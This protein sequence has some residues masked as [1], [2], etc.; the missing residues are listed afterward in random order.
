MSEIAA[1]R[2]SEL[3]SGDK[4]TDNQAWMDEVIK[5][6]RESVA[7]RAAAPKLSADEFSAASK[8]IF[9]DVD[10]DRDGFVALPELTYA[11]AHPL[12]TESGQI[13]AAMM[14]M[15]QNYQF[16]EEL[17]PHGFT[18]GGISESSINTAA[19]LI[20]GTI[21]PNDMTLSQV[22]RDN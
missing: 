9:K 15:Y 18:Q 20:K 8:Q 1:Q 10:F 12:K 11:L 7:K 13:H 19:G 4:Q 5:E 14:L 6:Y 2:V 21:N 17:S 3:Q 16:L 22:N